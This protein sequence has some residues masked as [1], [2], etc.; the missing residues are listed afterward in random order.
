MLIDAANLPE[1]DLNGASTPT[2]NFDGAKHLRVIGPIH[3]TN[4]RGAAVL[5]Q[6]DTHF[7]DFVRIEASYNGQRAARGDQL[8][9][10]KRR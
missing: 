4:G 6:E 5:I 10:R 1:G 2:W 3:L 9:S 8:R 7:V